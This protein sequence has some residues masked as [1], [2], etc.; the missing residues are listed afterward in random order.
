MGL[1]SQAAK[2]YDLMKDEIGIIKGDKNYFPLVP[3]YHIKKNIDL[4][5]MLKE[6]GTFIDISKVEENGI[7]PAT[8]AAQGRSGTTVAP[9]PLIDQGKYFVEEKKVDAYLA[10]LKTWCEFDSKNKAIKAVYSYVSKKTFLS[11][12]TNA[13]ISEDYLGKNVGWEIV[14]EGENIKTWNNCELVAS[15]TSF[16][17]A[18]F[19]GDEKLFCMISGNEELPIKIV[20]SISKFG[21]A[22]LVSSNDTSDYSFRGRFIKSDDAVS[23]GY[24]TTQKAINALSWLCGNQSVYLGRSTLLCWN[25]NGLKI[26]S[27]TLPLFDD[28]EEVRVTY[29]EY[30]SALDSYI[31][32]K[33]NTL[34]IN[35]RSVVTVIFD[36]PTT[37]RL[38]VKFYNELSLDDFIFNLASWDKECCWFSRY[39][40][41]IKSP[42][43]SDIMKFAFGTGDDFRT[44]NKVYEMNYPILVERRVSNGRI[45][46][47]IVRNLINKCSNLQIYIK[48]GSYWIADRLLFTTC[49]VLR[50]YLMDSTE[51]EYSMALEKDLADRSYQYGRLLA[52]FEK[53]EMDALSGTDNK[54]VTNAIRMQS[55]FVRRPGYTSK[56]ILE[57]LKSGYYSRFSGEKAGVLVYYEKLIGEIMNM[58][59]SFP[60]EDFDKPLD[61][62]YI[63][64]YYLQKNDFY[65]KKN[66]DKEEN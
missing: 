22:K 29:S 8:E 4:V 66:N 12:L 33:T 43:L 37:G 30:K 19:C 39:E 14:T 24:D 41:R 18:S 1:L 10:N 3:L 21:L 51:K 15:F 35:D 61:E 13:G 63:M 31:K 42:R 23:L 32:V 20:P 16:F 53:I 7:I 26:Q 28:E 62:T 17:K 44:D 65:N 6:D 46:T 50:K 36:S 47:E 64:G 54:R 2:T 59:S 9:F 40:N 5:V 52:V 27:P 55:M 45:P 60:L 11:D 49:C 58:I 48:D 25:P 38:S 56:I 34:E 57:K